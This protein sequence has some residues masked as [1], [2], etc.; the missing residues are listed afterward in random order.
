MKKRDLFYPERHEYAGIS[1][2]GQILFLGTSTLVDETKVKLFC[3]LQKLSP[4]LTTSAKS[5]EAMIARSF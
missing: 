4:F 2:S 5:A 3:L 1:I